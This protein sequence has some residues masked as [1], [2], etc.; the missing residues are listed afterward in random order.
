MKNKFLY[1]LVFFIL[2]LAGIFYGHPFLLRSYALFFSVSNGSRDA[3]ALVVLAGGVETRFP[4]AV[5]LY[6]DGY[7]RQILLTDYRV[8]N[9][10]L[11]DTICDEHQCIRALAELLQFDAPLCI[12]PSLKGGATSTFDEAYD[13]RAYSIEHHLKH[14]IIVTDDNHTRRALYAFKKVFQGTGIRL[15]AMGASND[16]FS[17]MNWWKTDRGIEA[18]VLEC[19]K[20]AVYLVSRRNVS[21]I[22]ND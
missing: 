2:A 22:K 1:V 5:Q 16:M 17:E 14:L 21:F 3:D 19:V 7:A 11:K 9:T 12:V 13:V 6:R 20:Y 8:R 18:Y 15:E 4:R 10:Q